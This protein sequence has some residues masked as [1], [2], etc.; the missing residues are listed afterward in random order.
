[1]DLW[2]VDIRRFSGLHRDRT[3]CATARSK[4]MASTIR[5]AF[6]MRNICRRPAAH[7]L[8]ALR[9]AKGASS[10][11]RLEARLGAPE[12]VRARRR[13]SP[14]TLILWGDRT[15]FAAVG[16][17]HRHVRER[18]RA[19]RP[20]ILR[21][22]RAAKART[23][24]VRWTGSAPTM[25]SKPAGR[26][27]YTQLLNSRGGIECGPDRGAAGGGEVLYRHRHRLP[28]PRLR[29]DRRSHQAVLSMPVC[30]TSRRSSVPCR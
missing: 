10:G 2:V 17:E 20:V 7:R 29:V 8:A 26:L 13:W 18:G 9:A 22:V 1:M 3:G 19:V 25:C 30:A 5:S 11:V 14:P 15:G 6:R 12:L 4:P 23:R 28:Q 24:C 16:E 27:T 21:E